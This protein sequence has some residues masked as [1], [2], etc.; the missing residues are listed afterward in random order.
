L[1]NESAIIA[2]RY[3]EKEISEKRIDEAFERLVM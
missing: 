2:A 1:I 3:N